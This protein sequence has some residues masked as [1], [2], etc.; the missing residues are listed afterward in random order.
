MKSM[1][2]I[3]FLLLTFCGLMVACS[4]GVDTPV[5]GDTSTPAVGGTT[6]AY[7]D[8]VSVTLGTVTIKYS[9]TSACYPSNEIF[10]FTATFGCSRSDPAWNVKSLSVINHL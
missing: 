5:N 8:T 7:K 1:P 2:R 3:L 4:K 10:A 6:S 9:K